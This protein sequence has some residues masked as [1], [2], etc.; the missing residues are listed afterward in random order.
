MEQDGPPRRRT[1]RLE[2]G[3]Q[4]ARQ[5]PSRHRKKIEL[6]RLIE[7]RRD[8]HAHPELAR[9]EYRTT[10]VVVEILANAGLKPRVLPSGTGVV[11]DLGAVH[12]PTV[13]LRA[14]LDALPILD[15]K[16]VEYRSQYDGICHACGHDVHTTILVGAALRLA[17]R[18]HELPGRI[19]LI[20]QPA[21]ESTS[22]GSLDVMASGAIENV[23]VMFALHCDPS[24]TVGNVGL[25]VGEITSAQDHITVSLQGKGGH[26]ARPHLAPN[27]I[28]ALGQIIVSLSDVVND[29]L[30]ESQRMLIGF[31]SMHSAGAKNAI[32][33][34][35]EASGTVR[36]PNKCVWPETP[37]L[38]EEAIAKLV[39]PF[40]VEWK[41]DYKRVCPSVVNDAA[42]VEVVREV[43]E[44]LL[45]KSSIFEA[46]QSFG[47]EDFSWYLQHVPGALFRLGVRS[48]DQIDYIDLHSS[49]FDIDERAIA[50]GVE[51]MVNTAISA[52]VARSSS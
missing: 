3:P 51:M 20:F 4:A 52:L 27:P 5:K 32:P 46:P 12:G 1:S 2:D 11:C 14:D 31:G 40:G 25:R 47:G 23:D 48:P 44:N 9:Q 34:Y 24:A 16:S 26:S 6:K 13:A 36:I 45:G 39:A 7:L 8:L 28:D 33:S 30:L 49:M 10:E 38:I 35:A 41:L 21:E 37:Q 50:I 17:Q 43:A 15:E 29:Q 18:Q 19:R 22:S 42:A